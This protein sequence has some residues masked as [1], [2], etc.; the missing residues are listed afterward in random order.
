M[1]PLAPGTDRRLSGNA[2]AGA[3]AMVQILTIIYAPGGEISDLSPY[4][5]ARLVQ[6]LWAGVERIV[7][8]PTLTQPLSVWSTRDWRAGWPNS[9]PDGS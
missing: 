8:N 9:A 6:S 1:G 2:A 7:T 5:N 4:V 3:A